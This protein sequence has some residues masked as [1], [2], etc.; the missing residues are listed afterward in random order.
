MPHNPPA[1]HRSR[2]LPTEAANRLADVR[3][4]V[5]SPRGRSLDH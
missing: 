3:V 1:T 2:A 4:V 5:E